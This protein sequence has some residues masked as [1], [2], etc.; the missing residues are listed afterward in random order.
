MSY[1]PLSPRF[2]KMQVLWM[3]TDDCR[4]LVAA[5]DSTRILEYILA[6][7]SGLSVGNLFIKEESIGSKKGPKTEA[8][9]DAEAEEQKRAQRAR[10]YK[11]MQ[12]CFQKETHEWQ[13]FSGNASHSDSMTILSA[14][15]AYWSHRSRFGAGASLLSFCEDHFLRAKALEEVTKLVEQLTRICKLRLDLKIL[16][17]ISGLGEKLGLSPPS[18]QDKVKI[19]QILVSG[20]PDR[21]ARLMS[22]PLAHLPPS[23]KSIPMYETLIGAHAKDSI[24]MIHRSSALFTMR[25]APEWILYEELEANAVVLSADQESLQGGSGMNNSKFS[26]RYLKGITIVRPEWISAL[27]SQLLLNSGKI[28]ES[29]EPK[30]DSDKDRVVG[31]TKPTYG[32]SA[33]NLNL[34]ERVLERGEPTTTLWM[35]RLYLEGRLFGS[36]ERKERVNVFLEWKV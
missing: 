10:Y 19:R 25:P 7:V 30:Y 16:P 21:M 31:Y 17:A 20:N 4:I 3:I 33:W 23:L 6:L 26:Q 9:Q 5:Q 14:V 22:E 8:T 32:P 28:L 2:S 36:L 1:F 27:G 12:V 18:S 24:C 15:G 29:P 35:A 34:Q 11:T 13:M